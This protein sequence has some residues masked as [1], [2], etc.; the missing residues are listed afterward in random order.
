[1]PPEL[2]QHIQEKVQRT[3]W[4]DIQ[5]PT[6]E[7]LKALGSRFGIHEIILKELEVPSVRAHV[8]FYEDYLYFVYN[9]PVFNP[10][11]QTSRRA[12][13]DFIITPH[14]VI[15]AHYESLEP[16]ENLRNYDAHTPFEMLYAI[17]SSIFR[18]EE[19]ELRHIR[20]KVETVGNELFKNK[21]KDVLRRISFLK[22]DISEY[23]MIVHSGEGTL[24]SLAERGPGWWGEATRVYLNEL[25]GEH[26]KIVNQIEDYRATMDDFERTNS[27]LMNAKTTEVMKTLTSFSFLTFPF[28]LLAAIFSMR[29]PG[30]PLE[31]S[32][33]AFWVVVG[34]MAFGILSLAIFFRKKDWL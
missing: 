3:T 29:L 17:L 1:M 26:F 28:M 5:N 18:F 31:N 13:L 4:I 21:E 16:L 2:T 8:E 20:E 30:M 6:P 19:R 11:E 12:E 32:A 24:N 15:T 23:R 22:R 27:Q 25:S 33:N 14:A 34:I 7:D 10:L 9:F